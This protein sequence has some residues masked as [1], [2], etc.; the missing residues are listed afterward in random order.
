MMPILDFRVWILDCS[1]PINLN[2]ATQSGPKSKIH[3]P[4][5]LGFLLKQSTEA[6]V[7]CYESLLISALSPSRLKEITLMSAFGLL[8]FESGWNQRLGN[9]ESR[10]QNPKSR[11]LRNPKS[12]IHIRDVSAIRN[13]KSTIQ[14]R[15][16][17]EPSGNPPYESQVSS[18]PG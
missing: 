6:G 1:V 9:P 15:F 2:S 12:K 11:R 8:D 4:K 10:I 3:N 18:I 17:L 5:S 16:T 13:P 7:H 14:S